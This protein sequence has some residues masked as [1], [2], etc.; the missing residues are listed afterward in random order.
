[1]RTAFGGLL[2]GFI[3]GA[4]VV[5]L[6]VGG[7][8]SQAQQGGSTAIPRTASGKPDLN[9]LWQALNTRELRHPGAHRA[10]GAGHASR[11]R[12]PVPAKEVMALG[13]VGA[14]PAGVGVVVDDEIPVHCPKL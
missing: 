12:R 10:A 13:A 6:G 7:H 3:S 14:V 8:T 1:M 2:A 5:F 9:G 11:A 4:A